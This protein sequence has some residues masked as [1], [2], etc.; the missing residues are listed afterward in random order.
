[1][2]VVGC[3]GG[4]GD[5]TDRVS[6]SEFVKEGS[7]I[8]VATRKGIR[9]DFEAYIRGRKGREIERAEQANEMT[10]E[11][12]AAKV[13]DEVIVPAMRQELEEFLSLGI[14]EG[15]DVQ[16]KALLKTFDEGVE[17]AER[18]PERAA[19]NGTEA[20]GESGRLAGEY[21]LEGC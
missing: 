5:K 1:M 13:G 2:I 19:M 18:H 4:D 21:G 15:D 16:V 6:K 14:P 8:C 3:G 11:E 9:S 7:A 10:A 12:A 20:F 17:K